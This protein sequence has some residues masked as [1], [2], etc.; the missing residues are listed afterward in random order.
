MNRVGDACDTLYR[1]PLSF[2]R[3]FK[4]LSVRALSQTALALSIG[5]PLTLG[6]TAVLRRTIAVDSSICSAVAIFAP[7]PFSLPASEAFS[8]L[9]RARAD[10]PDSP[11]TAPTPCPSLTRCT[12]AYHARRNPQGNLVARIVQSNIGARQATRTGPL[13]RLWA[14]PPAI[15]LP[16]RPP[17]EGLQLRRY[18]FQSRFTLNKDNRSKPLYVRCYVEGLCQTRPFACSFGENECANPVL[19]RSGLLPL[20]SH[21]ASK[22]RYL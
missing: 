22:H 19:L 20:P 4:K 14:A 13:R 17:C 12:A 9:R 6:R 18:R 16:Q 5:Q 10:I 3:S 15:M 21:I 8:Q 7:R 1:V 11:A 2:F